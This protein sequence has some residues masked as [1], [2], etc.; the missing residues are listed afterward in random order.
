MVRVIGKKCIKEIQEAYTSLS[1][2]EGFARKEGPEA[3]Q[4][5]EHLFIYL[6]L[7]KYIYVYNK[8]TY[9]KNKIRPR[10]RKA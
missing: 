4:G 9:I 1:C 5:K 7:F 8:H 6:Y 3:G 2:Q 10:V